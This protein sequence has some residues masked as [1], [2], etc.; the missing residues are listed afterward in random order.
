MRTSAPKLLT[1]KNRMHSDMHM[2]I[3]EHDFN[4]FRDKGV[5]QG[6]GTM[7]KI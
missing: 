2:Q 6:E 4:I 1:N 7:S 3:L 5:L